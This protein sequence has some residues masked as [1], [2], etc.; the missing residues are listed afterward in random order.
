MSTT[1]RP[2]SLTTRLLVSQVAVSV[3][4]ALTMVVVAVIAGPPLFEAHMREAGHDSPDVLAHSEEAFNTA[5]TLALLIGLLI[6]TTGAIIVSALISR[7]LRRSLDDLGGVASRISQGDYAQRVEQTDSREL[8]S[9]ADSFNTMASRLDSTEASRRRLLTDLAHEIRTPLASM[10][11]CVESLEDGAIEPGPDAWH[12]L[13]G[14]I[15]RISRLADDL[16]Q[17]SA[18]E[19]GRLNLTLETADPAELAREAVLAAE[20]GYG[21]KGVG[22][23]VE[24]S[25]G[26]PAVR[27]DRARIAQV[28]GN[29]LSN[30]LRHTPRG[31]HVIVQ[32]A[33]DEAMVGIEVS[34][35]GDGIA[36]EHLPH[37][38]ERFYRADAARNRDR[39]GTGVGL[40][41]SRAIALAHGGQL[42]AISPGPGKGSTFTLHL[43]ESSEPSSKQHRTG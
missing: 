15:E 24:P 28:L 32:V 13:T 8:A 11:I 17:V 30:A 19:E 26:L 16:G 37:I 21:R 9:L 12:I 1:N 5:G 31:G 14:Q 7:R 43:P 25:A 40:A 42:T 34:D 27:V 39:G 23:S 18:A 36:A 38:F 20:E 10:E 4:M 41:I 6:A 22:L 35:T 3:A 29:L 33:A 2:G